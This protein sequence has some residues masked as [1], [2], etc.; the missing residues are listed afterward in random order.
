MDKLVND[1]MHSKIIYYIA[2]LLSFLTPSKV[3]KFLFITCSYIVI[4]KVY[5]IMHNI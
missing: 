5:K 3:N 1:F 4:L 2:T